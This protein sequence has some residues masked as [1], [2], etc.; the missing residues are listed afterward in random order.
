MSSSF[1]E[2]F[3]SPQRNWRCIHIL[4]A[5]IPWIYDTMI[6][7]LVWTMFIVLFV[8][9]QHLKKYRS[10]YNTYYCFSDHIIVPLTASQKNEH[11]KNAFRVTEITLLQWWDSKWRTVFVLADFWCSVAPLLSCL[12]VYDE[13]W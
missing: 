3:L 11:E 7:W 10:K 1:Y 5:T 12:T 8:G 9:V 13:E 2:I 4:A 6:S